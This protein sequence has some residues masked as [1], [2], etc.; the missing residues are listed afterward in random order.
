MSFTE[1]KSDRFIS[2]AMSELSRASNELGHKPVLIPEYDRQYWL[3]PED[4]PQTCTPFASI[5]HV[6]YDPE[7]MNQ[8]QWNRVIRITSDTVMAKDLPYWDRVVLRPGITFPSVPFP[9][10]DFRT[11]ESSSDFFCALQFLQRECDDDDDLISSL[12]LVGGDAD[13][14]TSPQNS[15]SDLDCFDEVSPKPRR[16]VAPRR[17]E[18]CGYESKGCT[19]EV[20][21]FDVVYRMGS[22]L[23][24]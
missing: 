4:L 11:Y 2:M 20:D 22:V 8:A 19:D 13:G 12:Y 9:W 15:E 7:P 17:V 10:D 1:P 14:A 21:L 16:A 24:A 5:R 23:L 18:N 3:K 6:S